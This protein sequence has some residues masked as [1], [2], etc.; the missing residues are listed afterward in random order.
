VVVHDHESSLAMLVRVVAYCLHRYSLY[1]WIMGSHCAV[2]V[3]IEW[4]YKFNSYQRKS[5]IFTRV[6]CVLDSD[7]L[8]VSS[9]SY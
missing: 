2:C 3:A 8:S 5:H 1:P 4:P 7:C 9:L 6:C